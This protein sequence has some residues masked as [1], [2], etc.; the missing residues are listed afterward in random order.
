LDQALDLGGAWESVDAPASEIDSNTS[1]GF[2]EEVEGDNPASL[3]ETNDFCPPEPDQ[4]EKDVYGT[5]NATRK[6]RDRWLK[7]AA[8][9]ICSGKQPQTAKTCLDYAKV[10]GLDVALDR[11]VL[12]QDIE[13]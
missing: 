10:N 12:I 5:H 1:Q 13:V 7:F 6:T 4:R 11:Q 2:Q 9:A 8:A 3:L